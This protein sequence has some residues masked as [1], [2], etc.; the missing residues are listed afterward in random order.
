M[1]SNPGKKNKHHSSSKKV[2]V[3]VIFLCSKC[4]MLCDFCIT[5]DTIEEMS[6]N[7]ARTLLKSLK[8]QSVSNVVFGGGEPFAWSNDVIALSKEAK[9]IGLTVQVGT[10]GIDL[11]QGFETVGS[12]D[13]YVLPLDSAEEKIHNGL[14][15]YSGNHHALILSRLQK[16]RNAGKSVTLS[17]IFTRKNIEHIPDLIKFLQG[18][19]T[20]KN[21]IHAWHLYKFIPLGRGGGMRAAELAISNNEYLHTYRLIK[22]ANL[23]FR[24]YKRVDMYHSKTVEFYWYENGRIQAG[25][26]VWGNLSWDHCTQ[27]G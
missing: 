18:F 13:R 15:Q 14:R 27:P 3:A 6:F 5:N 12:I 25:N 23:E 26:D 20:D 21:I 7:R 24:I 4:N 16:L 19:T 9:Q 8:Q 1:S 22:S 17:T 10:N 2:K 11:P